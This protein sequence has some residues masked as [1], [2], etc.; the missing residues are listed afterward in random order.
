M[1]QAVLKNMR[2][3]VKR[4]R[5][6]NAWSVGDELDYRTGP[7]T[8]KYAHVG[9]GTLTVVVAQS[10]HFPG[11]LIGVQEGHE[12]WSASGSMGGILIEPRAIGAD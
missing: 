6:P 9:R 2:L 10:E 11:L 8:G 1:P 7:K 5:S 12:A 4:R 3:Q